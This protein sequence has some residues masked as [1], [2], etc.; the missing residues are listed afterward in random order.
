MTIDN[1]QIQK[2][3][4]T[5]NSKLLL[6]LMVKARKLSELNPMSALP[7]QRFAGDQILKIKRT[8]WKHEYKLQLQLSSLGKQFPSRPLEEDKKQRFEDKWCFYFIILHFSLGVIELT[9]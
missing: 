1:K 4:G 3:I 6:S 2:K 5:P 7:C 9:F 8:E